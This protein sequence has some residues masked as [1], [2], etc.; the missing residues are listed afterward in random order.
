MLSLCFSQSYELCSPCVA[1]VESPFCSGVFH[2]LA[3]GKEGMCRELI[4]IPEIDQFVVTRLTQ[5]TAP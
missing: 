1:T 2:F 4:H 5:P 3:K